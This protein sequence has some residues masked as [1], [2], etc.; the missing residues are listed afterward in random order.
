MAGSG[1]ATAT[2]L[3]RA[4][5]PPNA[6]SL[7]LLDTAR[8]ISEIIVHCTATPEGRDYTVADIRAWHKQRGFSDVGYHYV[9]YRDGRIMLGRPVGQI[10]AHVEGRNTGTIGI[11][12]IGGV[13]SDGKTAKDTRTAAQRASLLWLTAQLRAKHRGITKVSGHNE[14]AAK[15]CPSFNVRQDQL[16]LAA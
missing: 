9:I 8:Q 14:Y 5:P 4:S 3:D 15:A 1:P 13:S 2:L 6:A 11:S 12:Y 10:G 7:V 16:G